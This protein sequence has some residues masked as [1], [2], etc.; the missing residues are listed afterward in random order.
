VQERRFD[1]D[2]VAYFEAAGWRAYYD[3]KMLR[4]FRLVIGLCSEQFGI[5]FPQSLLGAYYI[6][7]ASIAWIPVDHDVDKVMRFYEKFYRVAQRYSGLG[8]DPYRAAALEL[9]YNDDH[10]RLVGIEEKGPLLQT[11]IELHSELFRLPQE[12]VRESAEWRLSALNTV[13]LI[14]SR[15]ST[16]IEG[17]WQSLL[18]D[19]RRCYRSLAAAMAAA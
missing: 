3:R 8:F 14:T 11:L 19:L 4:L 5:P 13:D 16:N 1:P 7:R 9:R 10:R 6:T 15:K 12:A 2:R 17:D 18:E